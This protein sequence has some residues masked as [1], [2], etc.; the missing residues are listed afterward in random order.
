M[1]VEDLFSLAS[2]DDTQQAARMKDGVRSGQCN[3][4]HGKKTKTFG[5]KTKTLRDIVKAEVEVEDLFGLASEDDT[6]QAARMKD[7]VRSGQ[8]N[9]RHGKKTKMFQEYQDFEGHRESRS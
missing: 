8:C 6:Q 4:R 3:A 1:D 5:K 7:G 2:E 9:A